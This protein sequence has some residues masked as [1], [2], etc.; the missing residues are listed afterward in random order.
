MLDLKQKDCFA[1]LA[2]TAV[3][4]LSKDFTYGVR[5][6]ILIAWLSTFSKSNDF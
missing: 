4:G 5:V 1:S 2:M 6:K 3:L